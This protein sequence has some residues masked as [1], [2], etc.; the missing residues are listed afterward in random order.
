MFTQMIKV[1]CDFGEELTMAY[2]TTITA[3]QFPVTGSGNTSVSK[4]L[5]S[6]LPNKNSR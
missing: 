1:Q 6:L 2:G 4:A 5:C 3:D